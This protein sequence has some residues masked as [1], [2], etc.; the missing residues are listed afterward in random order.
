MYYQAS[1]LY[2]M[3]VRA[4]LWWLGLKVPLK[5][6]M[7]HPEYNAEL[8][9]GGG[10]SQVPCLRIENEHGEARWMYETIDIIRYL[11]SGISR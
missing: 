8:T 7:F 4:A 11:E 6:I 3:A 1:C 5:D 9:A 10:K 2:C